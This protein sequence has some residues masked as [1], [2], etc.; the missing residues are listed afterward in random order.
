MS[1]LI[2]SSPAPSLGGGE[3]R[4]SLTAVPRVLFQRGHERFFIMRSAGRMNAEEDQRG[5]GGAPSQ[6]PRWLLWRGGKRIPIEKA[7][8]RFTPMPDSPRQLEELR[9][10]PGVRAIEPVTNGVFKVETTSTERDSAIAA[11][12]SEAFRAIAHHAY[13]PAGSEGTVYYLTDR[14]LVR[15]KAGTSPA[16]ANQLLEKY[17]LKV[18]REYEQLDRTCLVQVTSSSGENPL[19]IANRLAEEPA[20]EYA[21]PNLVNRFQ[22][23]FVPTDSYF[24]RQWHLSARNGAQLVAEASVDAP[25]RGTSRGVPGASW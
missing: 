13:G 2:A 19:K 17:K 7:T 8:E 16:K 18:L 10:V 9:R 12:R 21:E 5:V 4:P 15:F 11:A 1:P 24:R 20:V 6:G 3:A 14:I 25:T 23:A 22:P